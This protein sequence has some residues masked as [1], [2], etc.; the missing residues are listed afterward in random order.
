MRSGPACLL[1]AV[2]LL[3]STASRAA[4]L[5]MFESRLCTWCQAWHAEIGP[6]YPKTREGQIAPLRR[7]DIDAPRPADLAFIRG[8]RF[9]PT[10]VLID[11]G[12]EIGRITG[13]MGEDAFW[14]QLEALIN[15]LETPASQRISG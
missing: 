6:I 7:V 9:T 3:L 1:L 13:Y 5:I 4:E 15:R 12:R 2:T 8:I 14:G 11:G 10:F